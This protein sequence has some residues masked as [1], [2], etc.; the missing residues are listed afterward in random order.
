VPI[1]AGPRE[2]ACGG[3]A[4]ERCGECV[5]DRRSPRGEGCGQ[6]VAVQRLV[7]ARHQRRSALV[8][9][10]EDRIDAGSWREVAALERVQDPHGEPRRD[11]QC[12][13]C[14]VR[15]ARKTLRGLALQDEIRVAWRSPCLRELSHE[16][17]CDIERRVR[18]DDVLRPRKTAGE[19]VAFAHGDV[20]HIVKAS[21]QATDESRVAFDSDHARASASQRG[22]ESTRT[23]AQ[24]VDNV[25]RIEPG[26]RHEL[27]GE[28]GVG[29][30]VLC[31]PE[32]TS[33]LG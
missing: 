19:D 5:C 8:E 7:A 22:R 6:E 16:V 31:S 3:G 4:P 29:E 1:D 18:H 11:E 28:V 9:T 14:R 17:G 2:H 30:G 25:T 23:R 24:V 20:R 26:E 15:S 13:E 12:S 10:H 21:S 27:H 33:R 32:L